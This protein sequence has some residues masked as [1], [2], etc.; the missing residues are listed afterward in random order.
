MLDY[1]RAVIDL[2]AVERAERTL[3]GGEADGP[4]LVC[5][6]RGP[7]KA[8]D[9]DEPHD[10]GSQDALSQFASATVHWALAMRQYHRACGLMRPFHAVTAA[11][12]DQRD[13]L[14][15]KLRATAQAPNQSVIED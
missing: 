3:H 11:L 12:T 15:A 2:R 10:V 14:E 5:L 6:E 9:A 8:A 13:A 4:R 1:N 7:L